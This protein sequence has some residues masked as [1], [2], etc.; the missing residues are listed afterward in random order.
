M[1]MMANDTPDNKISMMPNFICLL[2]FNGSCLKFI[3]DKCMKSMQINEL[4]YFC[5]NSEIVQIFK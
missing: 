1:S 4:T 2:F 3:P 5:L